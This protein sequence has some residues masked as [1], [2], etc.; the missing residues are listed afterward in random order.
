MADDCNKTLTRRSYRRTGNVTLFGRIEQKPQLAPPHRK[1]NA[2]ILTELTQK[3]DAEIAAR[4]RR[5][6]PQC[7]PCDFLEEKQ[8]DKITGPRNFNHVWSETFE[9]RDAN[10][11]VIRGTAKYQA[12]GRTEIETTIYERTC[13]EPF[14]DD[15]ESFAQLPF[16]PRTPNVVAV[17]GYNL[18]KYWKA[19][20]DEERDGLELVLG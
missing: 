13:D 7:H 20:P 2:Q 5:P 16:D 3:I 9:L 15:A 19:L 4:N 18:E 1:T 14:G 10:G 12:T 8:I 11:N 17:A 6:P